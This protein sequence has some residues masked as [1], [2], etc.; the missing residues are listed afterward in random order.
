MMLFFVRGKAGENGD[1]YVRRWTPKG[2]AEA[3]PL[4]DIN[5]EFDELG[6]EPT[7]DGRSLYFYS[8]RSGG[9]GGYDL[10]VA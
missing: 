9:L 2:W 4:L 6:P 5:T 7:A 1:I 10:W 8:D 3:R